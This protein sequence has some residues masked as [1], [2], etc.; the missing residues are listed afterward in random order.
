MSTRMK[1]SLIGLAVIELVLGCMYLFGTANPAV[2]AVVT[3]GL[4]VLALTIALPIA[5]LIR[6]NRSLAQNRPPQK[7]S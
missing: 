5:A 1:G 2:F 4:P 6:S 7:S 3:I